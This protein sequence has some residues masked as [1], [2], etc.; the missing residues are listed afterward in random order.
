M[1]DEL[2]TR[3]KRSH[4][5]KIH[6]HTHQRLR[7]S[8]KPHLP[9]FETPK[10]Y[11]AHL[12]THFN[13]TPHHNPNRVAHSPTLSHK[14][15]SPPQPLA[16]SCINIVYK[17]ILHTT[18]YPKPQITPPVARQTPRGRD[19]GPRRT[20]RK[21]LGLHQTSLT[22]EPRRKTN[23]YFSRSRTKMTTKQSQS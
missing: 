6:I 19:D 23:V 22:R 21:N 3:K 9:S 18:L 12:T 13:S 15:M 7:H 5:A 17:Q 8:G 11:H 4:T 2:I 16:L 10:T 20:G 14:G 1:T